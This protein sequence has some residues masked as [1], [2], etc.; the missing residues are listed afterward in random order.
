[1][2]ILTIFHGLYSGGA[3]EATL[4]TKVLTWHATDM[5]FLSEIEGLGIATFAIPHKIV[6]N[7]FSWCMGDPQ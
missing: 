3:Q 5:T 6:A 1:L 4:E 2:G 7:W